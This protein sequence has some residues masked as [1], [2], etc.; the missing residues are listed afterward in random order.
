MTHNSPKTYTKYT[1]RRNRTVVLKGCFYVGASVCS[2]PESSIFGVRAVFS[3]D[4][5]RV[6]PPCVLAIVPLMGAVTGVVVTRA[7]TKCPAGPPLPSVVVTV[8]L[9]AGSAL[10]LLE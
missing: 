3:M 1:F 2:L 7:Y 4:S 9:G 5:C 10:W 6:F 8:L